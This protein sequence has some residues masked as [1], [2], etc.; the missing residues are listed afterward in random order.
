[1]LSV[2]GGMIPY[3]MRS[4]ATAE[5]IEGHRMSKASITKKMDTED[6]RA[7]LAAVGTGAG[8]R[9]GAALGALTLSSDIW[10]SVKRTAYSVGPSHLQPVMG[11]GH[12]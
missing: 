9:T 6:T 7:G 3:P 5:H 2:P 8:T 11:P 4:T 10:L 1:M 12:L